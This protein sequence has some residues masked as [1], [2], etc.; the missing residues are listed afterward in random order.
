MR[1]KT[2]KIKTAIDLVTKHVIGR[3]G[4]YRAIDIAS[5]L[6]LPYTDVQKAL[7]SMQKD[8]YWIKKTW[9]HSDKVYFV[10][11]PSISDL[12]KGD[13]EEVGY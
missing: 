4:S 9:D 8:L 6:N 5:A 10:V 12:L 2:Q 1:Y 3:P 11:K 7:E 13:D